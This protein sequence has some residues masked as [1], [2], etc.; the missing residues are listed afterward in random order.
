MMIRSMAFQLAVVAAMPAMAQL[1]VTTNMTPTQLVQNVLL[2]GGVT[3]SNV[4]FNGV[5]ATTPQ[6]GTGAFTGGNTT[7][8]GLDAGVILSSGLAT[9]VVGPAPG[10]ESD[11]LGTGSDPDLVAIT[12][13][14]N[15]IYDKSVLEFDFVP[16]GD[17]LKFSFVFGS[18]E[19]PSFNCSPT[20][21]DVFGFFL[22]GPG[23]NGPYT[24]NAANIALVPG[25]TLPVSIANIHGNEDAFCQ[26]VNAQYYVS[27]ANGTQITLNGFTVVLR[28][29]A[30]VMCGE[31]YHIKLAI[32]DAGD[33]IYNS[34]VF[35]QAGSFMSNVLPPVT[36]ATAYGDATTAEGCLGG[37]FAI[38]RPAGVDSTYAVDYYMTGTATNG[39]DYSIAPGPAV[40][41]AGQDS[42]VIP[43]QA[44]EDG[45]NE[46]IETAIMNIFMVNACGD[47]VVNSAMLAIIQYVPMEIQTQAFFLL[48]CD[49]DSIPLYATMSGGFGQTTLAWGDTLHSPVAYV[50]GMQNGTYTITAHDACPKSVTV[51]IEVDAG[52]Q[53]H[54]PNV[55]TPGHST[56]GF[57]DMFVVEG[58][59]GRDNQVQI[60]DRWGKEV[61]NT[62]NYQ[63]NFSFRGRH[64]GVYY[65]VIRVLEKQYTGYVQVLGS[66]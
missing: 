64:D 12:T 39:V 57:N 25:T 51:T 58:I 33:Q 18:E 34:T 3:V 53:V 35:L 14:G 55:T 32:G 65:Y 63:N 66:N 7:N 47:T 50:P 21:N 56:D 26:P 4:T 19:Y 38:F 46:G 31:T 16:N 8:L 48:Q 1:N 2:G 43:F 9:S 20:F 24:N 27:N 10:I 30:A 45:V 22:S 11:A 54:I 44:F 15:T 23:I 52:C 6:P 41:P 60:W 37:Y 13:P 62:R 42:V 29:E 49:Q 59:V 17:S 36:A 61:L 28:A 5:V 40:I